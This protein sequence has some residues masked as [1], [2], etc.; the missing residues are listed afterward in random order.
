MNDSCA[1]GGAAR[2]SGAGFSKSPAPASVAFFWRLSRPRPRSQSPDM[3]GSRESR[4]SSLPWH[5]RLLHVRRPHTRPSR[6]RPAC[7]HSLLPC[8]VTARL[9]LW[10]GAN[11]PGLFQGGRR[12]RCFRGGGTRSASRSRNSNGKRST[13][14]FAPGRHRMPSLGCD[15]TRILAPN[16]AF[17]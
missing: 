10:L 9:S 17:V 1:S 2:A 16:E 11:T 4:R 5:A 6:Y 7:R 3:R 12:C 14:P 13:T 8:A 15:H